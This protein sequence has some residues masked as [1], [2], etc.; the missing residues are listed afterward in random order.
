MSS[1]TELFVY[2]IHNT[3]GTNGVVDTTAYKLHRLTK[4]VNFVI[5]GY[6]TEIWTSRKGQDSNYDSDFMGVGGY[7]GPRPRQEKQLAEKCKV[8]KR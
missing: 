1:N 2:D 5:I 7:G 8:D 6:Y 3:R 4:I